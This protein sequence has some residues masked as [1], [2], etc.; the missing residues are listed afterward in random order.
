MKRE[1]Y[2]NRKHTKLRSFL[3]LSAL[4]FVLFSFINVNG[5]VKVLNPTSDADATGLAY[6]GGGGSTTNGDLRVGSPWDQYVNGWVKFDISSI[7]TGATISSVKLKY[8]VNDNSD[9][10]TYKVV[11]VK[12]SNGADF[13]DRGS[14]NAE[15]TKKVAFT[16]EVSPPASGW[17]GQMEFN[18]AGI[19]ELVSHIS[20]GESWFAVGLIDPRLSK[21]ETP[22][23]D[24]KVDGATSSNPPQLE[25]EYT[26]ANLPTA[27]FTFVTSD[28]TTA[29][30]NT[31][32]N[33]DSYSWDFGDGSPVSTAESP[34]H[35][36]ATNGSYD[37]TLT[38]TNSDGSKSSTKEVIIGEIPVVASFDYE[39]TGR[40]VSFTNNS[41]A[42][43]SY[44]WD[45]GD[46][47]SSTTTNPTHT[48][49]SN[50]SFTVTLTSIDGDRKS[51]AKATFSVTDELSAGGGIPLRPNKALLEMCTS[52]A[53]SNC[54]PVIHA[55]NDKWAAHKDKI[56]YI[57]MQA[58]EGTD[59][60]AIVGASHGVDLQKG[61]RIGWNSSYYNIDTHPSFSLNGSYNGDQMRSD[62]DKGNNPSESQL[63]AAA[64][65]TDGN[66]EIKADCA[67]EG[68]KIR[69][70]A[71]VKAKKSFSGQLQLHIAV[72]E[73]D[74]HFS[75]KPGKEGRDN[76]ERDFNAVLRYM[77]PN[78]GYGG[79]GG[80]GTAMA[81]QTTG[82]V[83]DVDISI[84]FHE[85][86]ST[87]ATALKIRKD[88]CRV[89]VFVQ[90]KSTKEV[91]AATDFPMSDEI[92]EG[93]VP[94]TGSGSSIEV[95]S[96]PTA[97]FTYSIDES[98]VAFTN[99]STNASSYSWDFGDG[100]TSTDKNPS[101]Y[102]SG[103]GEY[104][105]KLTAT[106]S[107]GSN[108]STQK[109][110]VE[111]Q[112]VLPVAG[113]SYTVSDNAAIFTNTSTNAT[114]YTW[115]FGDGNTS[116]EE[117][118][119]HV[120][121][122]YDTY[123]VVLTAIN[124]DGTNKYTKSVVIRD[125]SVPRVM[126]FKI[127]NGG[128]VTNSVI[129]I[130]EPLSNNDDQEIITG[131]FSVKNVSDVE[132]DAT[133]TQYIKTTPEGSAATFCWSACWGQKTDPEY[134]DKYG[135]T[136][137]SDAS[138]DLE[139]EFYPHSNSGVS[140]VMYTIWN[141]AD[142][143]D[144]VSITIKYNITPLTG[145]DAESSNEISI[146]P[147]PVNN[148]LNVD[149]SENAVINIYNMQGELVLTKDINGTSNVINML[150]IEKG[151]YFYS[152]ITETNEQQLG[153]FLKN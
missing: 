17:S 115:D 70:V 138:H 112:V 26:T 99:V 143:N 97:D 149:I 88:Y 128:E 2:K 113:F 71:S 100:K 4:V 140:E 20:A 153:K 16:S 95:G 87:Q 94:E 80:E 49:N 8:Y 59:S 78:G 111:K 116:M 121:S 124:S 77:L 123:T 107:T 144:S 51:I 18:S 46:G 122:S 103:A 125:G 43:T 131:K 34:S 37:V 105:V 133:V 109:V 3:R 23:Y 150:N 21:D 132:I 13:A 118:P 54:P 119:I 130:T 9:Y 64:N 73:D 90:N 50:G 76:G 148:I 36:Y 135:V 62:C 120:Y 74:L 42:A 11:V 81:T 117:N 38:A 101:H 28:K 5:E 29:F 15:F 67:I 145:V 40:E 127:Y 92:S 32:T 55:Y 22:K 66:F 61:G 24:I 79:K 63:L 139:P 52:T 141:K 58:A 151:L 104:T 102:Y 147:N 152:I 31:S 89:V 25:V 68:G 129:N 41:S 44:S 65:A 110:N 33:A 56:A 82:T 30:T 86:K 93:G 14:L 114:S 60:F 142:R 84:P 106:N 47:A 96:T 91:Y 35:T 69:A 134:T 10:G 1:D 136:L 27:D 19:D 6:S 126:S 53:C 146:Y 75:Y 83:T 98:T 137:V 85:N 7:P 48:Y 72:V 108:I 39:Y 12:I 45:F 57:Q